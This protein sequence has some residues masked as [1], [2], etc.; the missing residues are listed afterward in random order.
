MPC[1]CKRQ[2]TRKPDSYVVI[3]MDTCKEWFP[4]FWGI[5]QAGYNALLVDVNLS[6]EMV[7]FQIAQ[8]GAKAIVTTAS[9]P[10]LDLLRSIH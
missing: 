1:I 9:R 8:S 4:V 6:D 5:I 2:S 7:N 3:S 10:L